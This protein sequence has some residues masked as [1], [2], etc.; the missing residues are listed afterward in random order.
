MNGAFLEL[1]PLTP[2]TPLIPLRSE[3]PGPFPDDGALGIFFRAGIGG[4]RG[5]LA[6]LGMGRC[7]LR[8]SA[9]LDGAAAAGFG[10][11]SVGRGFDRVAAAAATGEGCAFSGEGCIVVWV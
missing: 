8:R 7:S 3:P 6:F 5:R 9:G 11:G 1:A 2:L 4:G 10:V